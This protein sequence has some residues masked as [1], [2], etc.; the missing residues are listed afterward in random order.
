MG[1]QSDETAG[2]GSTSYQVVTYNTPN[3]WSSVVLLECYVV[4]LSLDER[5]NIAPSNQIFGD[6]PIEMVNTN[7]TEFGNVQKTPFVVQNIYPMNS[8]DVNCYLSN[9][10]MT[11][12]TIYCI[13]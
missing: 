12:L 13:Q 11:N 9:Y 7:A 6:I 2:H 1:E 10:V 3:M 8:S 4:G 5:N